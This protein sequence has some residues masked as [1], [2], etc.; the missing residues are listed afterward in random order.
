MFIL[1]WFGLM[2]VSVTYWS[3]KL[4][5]WIKKVTRDYINVFTH[6]HVHAGYLL[7]GHGVDGKKM[8]AHPSNLARAQ[9]R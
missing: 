5:D 6:T 7:H 3:P 2:S 1:I 8:A 9:M 4:E